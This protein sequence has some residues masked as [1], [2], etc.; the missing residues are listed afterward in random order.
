M[1]NKAQRFVSI[2]DIAR[3]VDG[4]GFT[5]ADDREAV[6]ACGHREAHWTVT[7]QGN[8]ERVARALE[9]LVDVLAAPGAR[10]T[11]ALKDEY[12]R[13]R[14]AAYTA[15]TA[16]FWGLLEE[17]HGPCPPNVRHRVSNR[18][19]ME[20]R[21]AFPWPDT[22]CPARLGALI[23]RVP[24]EDGVERCRCFNPAYLTLYADWGRKTRLERDYRAWLQRNVRPKAARRGTRHS[25]EK[26]GEAAA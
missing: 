1:T 8:L 18:L 19:H 5:L 23:D 17:R 3:A 22:V 26:A 6:S 2:R 12:A 7:D 16:H 4:Q 25:A 13:R 11:A 14:S 10:A 21:L 15:G 20:F 9:T 24:D